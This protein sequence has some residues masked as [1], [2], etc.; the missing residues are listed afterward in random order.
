MHFQTPHNLYQ[1]ET[2]L[3]NNLPHLLVLDRILG[4]IQSSITRYDKTSLLNMKVVPLL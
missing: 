1:I 2:Y 4:D 3:V